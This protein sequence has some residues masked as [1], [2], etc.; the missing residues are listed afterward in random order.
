[1]HH[2]NLDSF[3]QNNNKAKLTSKKLTDHRTVRKFP[4]FYGTGR[5]ITTFTS[6]VPCPSSGPELET[7]V[8]LKY[9]MSFLL[10]Q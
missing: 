10:H 4:T 5:F 2:C 7:D 3:T 9:Y 6:A 1:M 8:G